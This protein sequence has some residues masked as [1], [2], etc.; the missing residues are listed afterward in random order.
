MTDAAM[1][2]VKCRCGEDSGV[3]MPTSGYDIGELA[4][5]AG[6]SWIAL[7]DGESVWICPECFKQA[8]AAAEI[9]RDIVGSD[10]VS[11]WTFLRK[12]KARSGT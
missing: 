7:A 6:Y 1:T 5:K 9:I 3:P 8:M 10:H 12:E 11:V 2:N 4:V